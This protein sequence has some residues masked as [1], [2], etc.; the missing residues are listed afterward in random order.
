M[1]ALWV[2]KRVETTVETMGET[3]VWMLADRWA[4]E[5]VELTVETMAT[6]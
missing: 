5:R 4:V 6:L 2:V 3:M 1:A